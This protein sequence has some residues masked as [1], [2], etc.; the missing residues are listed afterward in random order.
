[1][2]LYWI[3]GKIEMFWFDVSVVIN[4]DG[5]VFLVVVNIY[6][7]KSFNMKLEGIFEGV[8]V[9]VYIVIGD[10]LDCMNIVE[11]IEVGVKESKWEV[12]GMYDFFKV[13]M[14]MFRW[15]V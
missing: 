10:R 3:R 2:K 15:K 6:D 7:I 1:M 13:L 11:K 9:D 12:S 14:I 4:D 8:F 5:V